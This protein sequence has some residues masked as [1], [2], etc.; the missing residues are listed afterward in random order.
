MRSSTTK[1]SRG[2]HGL[3]HSPLIV[4]LEGMLKSLI[5]KQPE[6]TSYS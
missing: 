5:A 6:L 1:A 3:T 4:L 2:S